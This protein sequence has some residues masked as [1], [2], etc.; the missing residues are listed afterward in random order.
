MLPLSRRKPQ[1]EETPRTLTNLL[2]SKAP[3][4]ASLQPLPELTQNAEALS[5]CLPSGIRDKPHLLLNN[6]PKL[7]PETLPPSRQADTLHQGVLLAAG[8]MGATAR[9]AQLRSGPSAS[10]GWAESCTV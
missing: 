2:H 7:R 6:Q 8:E 10:R 9:R 3:A 5:G 4:T 1:L